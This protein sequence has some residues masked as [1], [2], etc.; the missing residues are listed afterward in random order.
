MKNSLLSAVD[1]FCEGYTGDGRLVL[2]GYMAIS[3]GKQPEQMDKLSK[4]FGSEMMRSV[5]NAVEIFRQRLGIDF[6]PLRFLVRVL[7]GKERGVSVVGDIALPPKE[8]PFCPSRIFVGPAK[9]L[10]LHSSAERLTRLL[11]LPVLPIPECRTVIVHP[12][13]NRNDSQ[14]EAILPINHCSPGHIVARV[15]ERLLL[16]ESGEIASNVGVVLY[17]GKPEFDDRTLVYFSPVDGEGNRVVYCLD[18]NKLAP[19]QETVSILIPLAP[20]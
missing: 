6:D 11:P 3:G 12:A 18:R 7:L 15:A 10:V 13:K 14:I 5:T 1:E 8:P 17:V 4:R 16:H 9:G 20:L 19:W 2:A